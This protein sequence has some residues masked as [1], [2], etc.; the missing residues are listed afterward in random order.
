[1]K[2]SEVETQFFSLEGLFSE[3]NYFI[4]PNYQRGYAWEKQ[5][6][7]DLWKDIEIANK[8]GREH[9]MGVLALTSTEENNKRKMGLESENCYDVIDGQQRLTT[10]FIILSELSRKM[11][12]IKERFL[13]NSAKSCYHLTYQI[14]GTNRDFLEENIYNDDNKIPENF[15]QTNLKTAKEFINQKI[16]NL[17]NIEEI[18][19]TIIKKLKFN[20]YINS[21]FF[22]VRKTFETLNFRGKKLSNLEL[23]KNKLIYLSTKLEKDEVRLIENIT[24]AW[25]KIYENLGFDRERILQDD[26]FLK[27]HWMIYGENKIDIK[28]RGESYA[29]DI[30][31][32]YFDEEKQIDDQKISKY[33]NSLKK[34]SEKWKMV[35]SPLKAACDMQLEKDEV[36][37]LDKLSRIKQLPFIDA[38]I[39]AVLSNQKNIEFEKRCELYDTLE[40]FIFI[41]YLVTRERNDLSFCMAYGRKLFHC[42]DKATNTQQIDKLIEELTVTR[43]N[44]A[45]QK[46]LPIAYQKFKEEIRYNYFSKFRGRNYFLYEYNNFLIEQHK[47]GIS[48]SWSEDAKSIEHI[49]PQKYKKIDSWKKVLENYEEE[50]DTII[51]SLGNLVSLRSVNK[52]ASLG[53][54]SY[55]IKKEDIEIQK[56]SYTKGTNAE[57]EIADKNE[58]WTV[59]SIYNRTKELIRFMLKNWFMGFSTEIDEIMKDEKKLSKFIQENFIGFSVKENEEA[60][61]KLETEL[62]SIYKTELEEYKKKH[63]I[64]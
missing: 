44:L 32:I 39:L 24:T 14:D 54:Q 52:N 48:V 25:E 37:A 30:L 17:S 1:M 15:Y 38:L 19:T 11:N 60:Q 49:L 21:D 34:C 45:I 5:Q 51:N 56:P 33:V 61:S 31:K 35:K 50:K 46:K 20:I 16:E 3:D 57:R 13:Y 41:N 2:L 42:N 26:E 53:N 18:Y 58:T 62:E 9:Y 7:E 12:E 63:S 10:I 28:A 6:I 27:A 23:L 59:Q 36:K 4:I 22:D 55:I 64:D 40:K 29:E 43:D 8:S 47:E